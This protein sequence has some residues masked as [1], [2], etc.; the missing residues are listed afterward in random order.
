[1]LNKLI[2][3]YPALHNASG[4]MYFTLFWWMFD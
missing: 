3:R 2:E 4:C 1:M